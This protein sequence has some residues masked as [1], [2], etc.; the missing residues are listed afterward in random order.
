MAYTSENTN[1]TGSTGLTPGMQTY[2]NRE[3]LRTFEPELV[4]LQFGDEHRMPP[5]AGLVMN[6]RKIIPLEANTAA[7]TEGEPG[8]SVMLTETEVT[9][10]LEVYDFSGRILWNHSE[11]VATIDNSYS[12]EWNLCTTSGQPLGTGVYLYRATVTSAS[13]TSASRVRKLT[14]LR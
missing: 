9:V 3:L 1:M 5:N 2:Y 14:I 12:T 10:K 6:M 11:Q 13:G 7:L 8:E 4:H